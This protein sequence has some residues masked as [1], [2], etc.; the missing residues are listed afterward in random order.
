MQPLPGFL[1]RADPCNRAL[2]V[3]NFGDTNQP[4]IQEE[5]AFLGQLSSLEFLDLT[6]SLCVL[7]HCGE[8]SGT[9]T[10]PSSRRA[11][12]LQNAEQAEL[13]RGNPVGALPAN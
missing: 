7:R 5:V 9:A 12:L 11:L 6:R 13:E 8:L 3:Q 4:F 1:Q 10:G 2:N